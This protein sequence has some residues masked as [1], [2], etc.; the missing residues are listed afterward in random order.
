MSSSSFDDSV[1]P[2]KEVASEEPSDADQPSPAEIRKHKRLA[3]LANA[4]QK[5]L[6]ANKKKF[7]PRKVRKELQ[8]QVNKTLYDQEVEKVAQLEKILAAQ[9][10]KLEKSKRVSDSIRR[11]SRDNPH[12]PTVAV[13]DHHLEHFVKSLFSC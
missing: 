12:P 5:A 13:E 8:K 2:H 10:K 1:S 9:N 7:E 6:E 3:Q 4:R 11:P